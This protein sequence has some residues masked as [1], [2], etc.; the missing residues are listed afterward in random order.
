M[1]EVEFDPA[2]LDVSLG[3]DNQDAPLSDVSEDIRLHA[4]DRARLSD[5]AHQP[6]QGITPPAAPATPD[7]AQASVPEYL[8][9]FMPAAPTAPATE[10][11]APDW[12]A[13]WQEQFNEAPPADSPPD[14]D[15]FESEVVRREAVDNFFRANPQVH[16]LY[17]ITQNQVPP[18]EL[19]E[20]AVRADL[21]QS[22]L[23]S[24][25]S[26]EAEMSSYLDEDG[27]L[28]ADGQKRVDEEKV[29]AGQQLNQLQQQAR[30]LA[31][32]T[33]TDLAAYNQQLQTRGASFKPFGIDLPT[34]QITAMNDDIR[35]GKVDAWLDDFS[36]QEKSIDR[37]YWLAT[38]MDDHRL[39]TLVKQLDQRGFRHGSGRQLAGN[40][41]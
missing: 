18:L 30:D 19:L 14:A 11:V 32:K 12:A 41:N 28:T 40:F 24:K 6:S 17:A 5:L 31:D 2:A 9:S 3:I 27:Q 1:N 39:A 8:K 16:N 37:Y 25:A 22:G 36:N 38:I 10:P 29:S 33:A 4:D 15:S 7:P 35:S 21:K 34:D 13:R 26:Y 23:R 20:S